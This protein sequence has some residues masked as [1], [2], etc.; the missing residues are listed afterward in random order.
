[1]LER[2]SHPESN[3]GYAP[4]LNE[5]AEPRPSIKFELKPLHEAWMTALN[6]ASCVVVQCATITCACCGSGRGLPQC[7]PITN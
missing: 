6:G 1:M 7:P 2:T 4:T 5:N 3:S